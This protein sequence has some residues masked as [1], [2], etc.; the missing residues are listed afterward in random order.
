VTSFQSTASAP[1]V[2]VSTPLAPSDPPSQYNPLQ[3]YIPCV[4]ESCTKTYTPSLLGPTFYLPQQPYQLSRKR[5]LC[6][7]HANQDLKLANHKA[8]CMF[9]G[10]RQNCGRKTLGQIAAE[11]EMFVQQ[12]REDRAIESE[13]LEARQKK[14]VLGATQTESAKGKHDTDAAAVWDWRF[15]PRPCTKK[16]CAKQWCSPFDGR[17]FL[18]YHTARPS[19]LRPLTTLC[20]SCAREDVESAEKRIRE[21]GVDA[22]EGPEWVEWCKQVE[23]DRKMEEEFWMH[24]QERVVRE[25]AVTAVA[26]AERKET[27]SEKT[28][29]KKTRKKSDRLKGVCVVM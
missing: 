19:G 3:H 7:W 14:V 28:G 20:P 22:G 8:K 15:T 6:S 12:C 5:A 23:D 2:L 26:A 27:G 9:E 29:D 10:M 24:A 21:R 16:A 1:A 17:L 25:K 11:F 13:K 18:F 4:I